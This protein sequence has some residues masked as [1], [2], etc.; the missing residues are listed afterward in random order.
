LPFGLFLAKF[1]LEYSLNHLILNERMI[2]LGH[3]WV[4]RTYYS[5]LPPKRKYK[6]NNIDRF[7]EGTEPYPPWI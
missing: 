1:K 4:M 6:L 5:H 2:A 3:A 7:I